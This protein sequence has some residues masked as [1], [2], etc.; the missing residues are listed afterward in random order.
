MVTDGSG[1]ASF[2]ASLTVG[3]GVFVTATATDA[4]GNTSEFSASLQSAAN[5][6]P[7]VTG[8]YPSIDTIWPPNGK[9]VEVSILGVTDP[10]GDIVTIVIESITDDESDDPADH[11]GIGTDRAQVRARRDGKGDGRTYTIGFVADDGVNPPVPNT[12]TVTVAHDQGGGKQTGRAKPTS[13]AVSWGE[14]KRSVR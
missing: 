12:V 8:A 3:A 10:E 7:V 11:G 1:K 13:A 6:P 5:S 14:V 9:M 4:A 2:S